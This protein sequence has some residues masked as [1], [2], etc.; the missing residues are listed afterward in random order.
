MNTN[1]YNSKYYCDDTDITIGKLYVS[2]EN[3]TVFSITTF[4]SIMTYPSSNILSLE[5]KKRIIRNRI[6]TRFKKA[7]DIL[8]EL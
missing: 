4:N 6:N 2:N 1:L 7:W 3:H 8:A 5:E